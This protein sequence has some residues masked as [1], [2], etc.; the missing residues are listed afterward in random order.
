MYTLLISMV[1]IS[2]WQVFSRFILK[3]SPSFTTEFLRYALLW[4]AMLAAAYTFGKKGHLSILFIKER[5]SGKILLLI[6]IGTELTII[7][8]ALSVLIYGGL[9]G[10]VVGMAEKSATLPILIGYAYLVF[11]I[12]GLFIVMYSLMH[13]IDLFRKD[14]VVEDHIVTQSTM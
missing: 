5:L 1:F 13:I 9:Q 3:D 10:V 11:P 12:S 6:N 8:F 4:L 2:I 7:F 14:K